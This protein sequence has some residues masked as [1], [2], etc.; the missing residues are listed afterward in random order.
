MTQH[1]DIK[2]MLA[3]ILYLDNAE[4]I[5]DETPLSQYG[6]SS[7]DFIDFCYE[8]QSNISQKLE[9]QVIWP[10]QAMAADRK[11][12]DGANWTPEGWESVRAEL[13]LSADHPQVLPGDLSQFMTVSFLG[14]RIAKM[15]KSFEGAL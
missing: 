10:F 6:F 7:L 9:P 2:R 3:A 15:S 5:N 14:G 8:V 11:V 4:E 1:T 13:G 12:F